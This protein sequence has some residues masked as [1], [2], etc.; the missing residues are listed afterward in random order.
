MRKVSWVLLCLFVILQFLALALGRQFS[1]LSTAPTPSTNPMDA[2]IMMAVVIIGAACLLYAL[3][4]Q[5]TDWVLGFVYLMIVMAF[6]LI[7]FSLVSLPL[8]DNPNPIINL[9]IIVVPFA[10][11]IAAAIIYSKVPKSQPI[12]MSVVATFSAAWLGLYFDVAIAALAISLFALYDVISVF[13]TKHMV[14]FATELSK[15]KAIPAIELK[16]NGEHT[17]LGNGDIMVPGALA[18]AASRSFNSTASIFIIA[19][20]TIGLAIMMLI[21]E[22]KRGVYPAL[23]PIVGGALG[24]LGLWA[25]LGT[26]KIIA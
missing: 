18:V 26:L 16:V 14:V 2:L 1:N 15:I 12:V 5:Q 7:A 4:H 3:R 6:F 13:I 20:S 24:G 8:K 10:I 21:L 22:R 19:G 25:L 9:L 23:P 17:T 11:G